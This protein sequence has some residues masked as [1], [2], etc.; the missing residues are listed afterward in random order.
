MASGTIK[1]PAKASDYFV[2]LNRDNYPSTA[3]PNTYPPGVIHYIIYSSAVSG[4]PASYGIIIGFVNDQYG[5]RGLQIA[6]D[7]QG[8]TSARSASNNNWSAWKTL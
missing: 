7:Y 8:N 3:L 2:G 6:I 1:Q 4:M 5:G